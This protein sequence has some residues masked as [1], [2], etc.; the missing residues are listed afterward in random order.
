MLTMSVLWGR[1]G[2][3]SRKVDDSFNIQCSQSKEQNRDRRFAEVGAKTS[4]INGVSNPLVSWR[5]KSQLF[6]R[7]HQMRIF[8]LFCFCTDCMFI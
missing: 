4:E 1:R 8:V 3:R 5:G 6:H 2:L 7:P